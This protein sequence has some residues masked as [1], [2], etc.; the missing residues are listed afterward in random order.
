M[1]S[2]FVPA[3]PPPTGV[4]PNFVNPESLYPAMA[5]TVTVC[6]AL[7]TVFTA[8]RLIAKKKT[9]TLT[10]EDCYNALFIVQGQA[11][12]GRHVWDVRLAQ[13]IRIEKV[14]LLNPGRKSY[15][16][17]IVQ[18][19]WALELLYCPTIWL[20]KTALLLQL[21]RV[22]TTTAKGPIY[23][24]IHGLIWANLLFYIACFFTVL[25]ECIPQERTW[26]PLLKKGHCIDIEAALESTG[27][28]NVFSDLLI[29]LL[30]LWAIW[31][32]QMAPQHKLKAGV[33]CIFM[34]GLLAFVS[35]ICRLAYT[36]EIQYTTDSTY[37]IAQVALW[38]LAEISSIILCTC[39]PM[40]PRFYKLITSSRKS[41]M[42]EG[43]SSSARSAYAAKIHA[44]FDK[45]SGNVPPPWERGDT[46]LARL[47]EPYLPLD[48][49]RRGETIGMG[50]IHKTVDVDV[51]REAQASLA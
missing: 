10:T 25:L 23:W 22:F 29:L 15:L 48:G 46:E 45:T 7:T 18:L 5:A 35:S 9:S 2:S 43:I 28:V 17:H 3:G 49:E 38:T 4:E 30:P 33:L 12:I 6:I 13:S 41:K 19:S 51:T 47:K 32:L 37:K 24:S 14:P 34:T 11:G 27:A 1:A 31:R 44:G 8:V 50:I 20:A 40:M 21:M 36:I 16:T 42:S 26:N 39:F